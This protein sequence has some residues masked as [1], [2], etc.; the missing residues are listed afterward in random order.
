LFAFKTISLILSFL[1]AP[2]TRFG[3]FTSVKSHKVVV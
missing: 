1:E 2:L 3:I